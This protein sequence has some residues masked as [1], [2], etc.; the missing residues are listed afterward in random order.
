MRWSIRIR[1]WGLCAVVLAVAL[2]GCGGGESSA[3]VAQP[4]GTLPSSVSSGDAG[5]AKAESAG[6]KSILD[7]WQGYEDPDAAQNVSTAADPAEALLGKAARM[8][9]ETLNAALERK[10]AGAADRKAAYTGLV[11]VYRFYNSGTGAHFYTANT[12]ERD[13]LIASSSF[14][15]YEGAAFMVSP[16]PQAGLAPVYRFM[17]TSTGVHLYTISETERNLIQNSLPDY[18]LEGVAYYASLSGGV[19]LTPLYRFYQQNRKFHF[20]TALYTERDD[21]ISNACSYRYEG[22]AYYVFDANAV[23][24]PP[25]AKPSS[26]VLIVGDSLAE[27]Y[28]T[29]IG[30]NKYGFVTPGQVW[31]ERLASEIKTRTARSCNKVIDVSVGGMR[32][33]EGAE[34]IQAWL[35]QYAP[36]HVILAQ[37]TND[38]WQNRG[39]ASMIANLTNMAQASKLI[40][41][42]VYVM[43]F[44]FFPKGTAYRQGM[45][46]MYQGVATDTQS[47]YINGTGNVPANSTYYHDDDVHLKDAAQPRVLETVWAALQ[48]FL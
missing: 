18:R 17:N 32:T 40:G 16:V 33:V 14:F 39:V 10:A 8:N 27:G 46:A 43:E 20:Y 19:G 23:A 26:V 37:G 38:A 36:T 5:Q 9:R 47:A 42:N 15:Q 31:T 44:A 45:S 29:S 48:P 28:G 2:V 34:G 22:L 30:G 13:Q 1:K 7:E 41:A 3:D 11:P 25:A 4:V 6:Q 24:D 12:V 21:L 35:D